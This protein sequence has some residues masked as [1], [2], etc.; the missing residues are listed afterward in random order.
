[1]VLKKKKKKSV[2]ESAAAAALSV[3]CLRLSS[4]HLLNMCLN[5]CGPHPPR[6]HKKREEEQRLDSRRLTP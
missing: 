5:H 1:M 6:K 2:L 4:V 3:A